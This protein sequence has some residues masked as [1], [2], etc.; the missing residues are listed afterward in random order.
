LRLCERAGLCSRASDAALRSPARRCGLVSDRRFAARVLNGESKHAP[1]AS[2]RQEGTIV[3][4]ADM[5]VMILTRLPDRWLV[6][7]ST[8]YRAG[9][10]PVCVRKMR[11]S[12]RR[13]ASLQASRRAGT[14]RTSLR[15]PA[16]SCRSR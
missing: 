14:A 9:W 2:K 8:S 6:R 10:V 11:P 15:I 7:Y 1:Q 3:R 12:I 16:G 13:L 4:L 5:A